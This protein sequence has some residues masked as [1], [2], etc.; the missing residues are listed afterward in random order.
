MILRLISRETGVSINQLEMICETASRRYRNYSIPKRTGG[1]RDINHPTPELKF[2]QRWLSRNVLSKLPVH[3]SAY[4]YRRGRSIADG[5]MLHVKNSYL[6]KVDFANFFPSLKGADVERVLTRNI[7]EIEDMAVED[8]D[9]IRAIVCKDNRLTIGSPSS[10]VLSNAILYEFDEWLSNK[11]LESG[12]VYS[13]YADD[14]FVSTNQS[15]VLSI[16]L[17]EIRSDIAKREYPR[18]SI[19]DMKTVFTSAKHRR[20]M[21]GVVLTSDGRISVGRSKKRKIKTL[22]YLYSQGKLKADM[23]SYLQGYLAFVGSIETDF[24][25]SLEKKFGKRVIEELREEKLTRRKS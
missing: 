3:E 19:N 15:H 1:R 21:T 25:F 5:A 9:T 7:S 20:M 8:V 24:V 2:L 17:D 16:L 13:R 11:V 10:P 18:L 12:G 22:T 4:A 14:L 6:L 23:I